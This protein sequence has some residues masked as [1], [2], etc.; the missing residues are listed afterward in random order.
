MYSCNN[1]NIERDFLN[2]NSN[3]Y[4]L[5]VYDKETNSDFRIFTKED[6]DKECAWFENNDMG[7]LTAIDKYSSIDLNLNVKLARVARDNIRNKIKA[8]LTILY[9]NKNRTN[10]MIDRDTLKLE[11]ELFTNCETNGKRVFFV[12]VYESLFLLY[13]IDPASPLYEFTSFFQQL[14]LTSRSYDKIVEL[15]KRLFITKSSKNCRNHQ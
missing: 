7:S 15:S 1:A 14:F 4:V 5:G 3:K 8:V 9:Q 11:Q 2:I 10:T 13:L 12:Y 6:F